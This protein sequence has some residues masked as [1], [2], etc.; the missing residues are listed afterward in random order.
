MDRLAVGSVEVHRVTEQAE[1]HEGVVDVEE[2]RVPDVGNGDA[3]ADA[4]GAHRFAGLEHA[5]EKGP[6]LLGWERKAV[7]ERAQHPGLGL[8]LDVVKDAAG[9]QKVGQP[10]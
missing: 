9:A 8:A 1:R 4:G 7:H 6:V 5:E 3:V 10:E 2:D